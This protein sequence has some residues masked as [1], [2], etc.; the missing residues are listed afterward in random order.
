MSSQVRVKWII[1]A[2]LLSIATAYASKELD[3]VKKDPNHW[4]PL[5]W[6]QRH[7]K[8]ALRPH[9]MADKMTVEN[10]LKDMNVM[11]EVGI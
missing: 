8:N 6:T 5:A 7:R 9:E 2:S 4:K 11:T 3:K 10:T 1:L